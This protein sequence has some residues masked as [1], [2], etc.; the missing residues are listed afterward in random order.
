MRRHARRV[1]AAALADPP[2]FAFAPAAAR[3][4]SS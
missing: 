2:L 4:L 3:A 1:R